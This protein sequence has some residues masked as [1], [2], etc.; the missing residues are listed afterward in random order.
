MPENCEK[1]GEGGANVSDRILIP[2]V[3][4]VSLTGVSQQANGILALITKIDCS[5]CLTV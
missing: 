1:M 2:E 5:C 3:V 4:F